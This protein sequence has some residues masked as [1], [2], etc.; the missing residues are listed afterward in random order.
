MATL[1]DDD[2]ASEAS[3]YRSPTSIKRTLRNSAIPTSMFT[4]QSITAGSGIVNA[5]EAVL[6]R[7]N[8]A[9]SRG[10]TIGL[11]ATTIPLALHWWWNRR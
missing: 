10:I 7:H 11:I 9:A 6:N 5:N 3:L 8:A 2:T 1:S 4:R